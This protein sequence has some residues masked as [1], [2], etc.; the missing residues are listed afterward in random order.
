MCSGMVG[1]L[2]FATRTAWVGWHFLYM[3]AF[4]LQ[5]LIA[6]ACLTNTSLRTNSSNGK[7]G[8]APSACER[9]LCFM[10]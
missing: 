9:C 8:Y 2:L 1:G 5:F 7:Q 6:H 3:S 4:L 10:S